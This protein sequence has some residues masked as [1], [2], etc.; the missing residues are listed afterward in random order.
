VGEGSLL[1]FPAWLQHSVDANRSARPRISFSF[2]LMFAG[3]E[4]LA[5][6]GWTPGKGAPA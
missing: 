6:P 1:L 2:N 3:F 5:R 4:A